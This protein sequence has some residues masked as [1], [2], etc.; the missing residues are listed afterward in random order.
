M[1]F[2]IKCNLSQTAFTELLSEGIYQV[3]PKVTSSLNTVWL[4]SL[5]IFI[6]LIKL[7][8]AHQRRS[9]TQAINQM[10]TDS[11]FIFLIVVVITSR[12]DQPLRNPIWFVLPCISSCTLNVMV[13]PW[14][15][16]IYSIVC[17]NSL[18]GSW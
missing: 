15:D 11:C 12:S 7:T 13:L 3:I 18:P 8:F 2:W 10:D 16:A 4:I 17:S 1:T 6:W 14:S 5:R 9:L